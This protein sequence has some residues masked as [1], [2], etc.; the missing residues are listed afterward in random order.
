MFTSID[1]T[2]VSQRYSIVLYGYSR[3]EVHK[4]YQQFDTCLKAIIWS[5][6]KAGLGM[7]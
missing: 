3:C 5:T 7:T 4:L 6:Y 1:Y 2:P